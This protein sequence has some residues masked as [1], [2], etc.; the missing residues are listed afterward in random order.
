M[1]DQAMSLGFTFLLR[2]V[3]HTACLKY[4]RVVAAEEHLALSPQM[5]PFVKY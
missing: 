1:I 4:S 3:G 2:D 5:Q